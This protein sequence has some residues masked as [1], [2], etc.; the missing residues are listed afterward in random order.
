[1]PRAAPKASDLLA[2]NR[3][4]GDEALHL[5]IG[6]WTL[7]VQGL[8]ASM[9]S[10]LDRR[11]G[12]FLLDRSSAAARITLRVF[13]SGPEGWLERWGK[14]ER[15]RVEGG[16]EE[17]RLVVRSYHF[18]LCPEEAPRSW[19]LG[20]TEQSEEPVE[21]I[22]D[23]A[24][25]CLV[26]R[27]ATEEGGLALHGAGVLREGLAYLFA[28]PSR[29]GKSTAVRLSSPAVS[30]GDDYAV[31][32]RGKGG[33]WSAPAV[34][35]EN[36][37]EAPPRPPQ[38]LLPLAGVWRLFQSAE[39]RVERPP[40]GLAIASLMGCAAFPRAM[41]DLA[42]AVLDH[43][44]RFVSEAAFAHLHFR[45]TADFWKLIEFRGQ[46]P[47]PWRTGV[48]A[49]HPCRYG[50]GCCPRTS[51]CPRN[52]MSFQKSAVFRKWR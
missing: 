24:V 11:W 48:E 18:A 43:A 28:G 38:G 29:S 42:D 33:V 20:L 12:G 14:G 26:A 10:A 27:V 32:V 1:M 17:D 19:R 41:P 50:F 45:K 37:E 22:L 36:T 8:D 35:F 34:P 21:R 47:K 7:T 46:Q 23:N 5:R 25:R 15:Y 49:L 44:K 13:P 2:L 4:R 3:P 40:R 30:L 9:V 31:L 39:D 16:I 51:C 6:D 52:S